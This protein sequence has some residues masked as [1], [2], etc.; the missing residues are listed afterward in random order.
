MYYSENGENPRREAPN[1]VS[2]DMYLGRFFCSML[3][4]YKFQPEIYSAMTNMK[5]LGMN[6]E[7]F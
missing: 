5:Y 6:F 4:H 2:W 3:F 1:T 7:K